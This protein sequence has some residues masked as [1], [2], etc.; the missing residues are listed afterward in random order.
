MVGRTPCSLVGKYMYLNAGCSIC[1]DFY[2]A[3]KK[4]LNSL[5]KGFLFLE[6][7]PPPQYSSQAAKVFS[8]FRSP[9]IIN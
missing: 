5:D 2:Q 6:K 1:L 8:A 4:D 3:R 9:T 7:P